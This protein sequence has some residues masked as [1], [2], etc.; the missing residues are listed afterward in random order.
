MKKNALT[1][2]CPDHISGEGSG[3]VRETTGRFDGSQGF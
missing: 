1:G 2:V 3:I